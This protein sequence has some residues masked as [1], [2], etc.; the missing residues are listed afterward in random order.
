[1]H[2]LLYTVLLVVLF[3]SITNAQSTGYCIEG[4]FA[5]IPYFELSEI[6]EIKDVTYGWAPRWPSTVVDTLKMD[7]YMPDPSVDPLEVRPMVVMVHGGSFINGTRQDMASIC[8]EYAR[9]GFVAATISYRLGWDC[10]AFPLFICNQ[11]GPEVDKLR[12]AAYRSVQDTRASLRY[13]AFNADEYKIDPT[14]FFVGGTSAGSIA[15]INAH[16]LDQDKAAIFCPD[17]V[18]AVGPLDEGVN[19]IQAEYTIRGLLNNC[20]ATFSPEALDG[21]A[22]TPV[23]SFHDDGDCIVPS[24]IG[25]ALGCFNCTS[26]FQGYGSQQIHAK[27]LEDNICSRLNLRQN[28]LSHCSFA[29]DVVINRSSCFMKSIF[30]ESCSSGTTNEITGWEECD[31]QG[32]PTSVRV[33]LE[34]NFRIYPNPSTGLLMIED[35]KFDKGGDRYLKIMDLTGTV[36]F[37]IKPGN[38]SNFT[39]DLGH[40]PKGMFFVALGRGE[41]VPVIQKLLIN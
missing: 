23:I 13:L 1:M 9:R 37:S 32:G 36:V 38:T 28:S 41:D 19:T 35:F 17:C 34:A 21:V 11:C 27:S 24:N 26:F 10:N 6:V 39:L 33:A 7:I 31:Q 30:C 25:W 18:N 22:E 20:G 29:S 12:V 15:A 16:Y 5:Q 40:L 8:R 3:N 4:R 2:R 14:H